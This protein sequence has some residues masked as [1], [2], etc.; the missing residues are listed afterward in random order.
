MHKVQ[1]IVGKNKFYQYIV[2]LLLTKRNLWATIG[3]AMD[4]AVKAHKITKIG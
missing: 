4:F 2:F 3:Y 1:I